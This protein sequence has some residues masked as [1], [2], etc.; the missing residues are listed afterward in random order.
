[1]VSEKQEVKIK[2]AL[3]DFVRKEIDVQANPALH[4][5]VAVNAVSD[6]QHQLVDLLF[7]LFIE[8]DKYVHPPKVDNP[9]KL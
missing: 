1:M 4:P 8:F 7:G 9:P 2:K 6:R 5:S 3:M